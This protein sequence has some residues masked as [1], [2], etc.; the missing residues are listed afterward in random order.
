M[1]ITQDIHKE[2]IS[3]IVEDYIRLFPAEY[4]QFKDAARKKVDSQ[5]TKFGEVKGDEYMVRVLFELPETLFGY[6]YTLLPEETIDWLWSTKSKT[7]ARWFAGKYKA[8]RVT[9]KV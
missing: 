6:M 3:K 5:R 4:K 9:E 1:K 8:F 7:G 2:R